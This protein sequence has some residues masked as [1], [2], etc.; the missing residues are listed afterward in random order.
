MKNVLSS[1]SQFAGCLWFH[2]A[3]KPP[4][5]WFSFVHVHQVAEVEQEMKPMRERITAEEK[6]NVKYDQKV[7][8]WE[9]IK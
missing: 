1:N 3:E 6:S 8:E 5:R 2:L 4:C 7:E 9:V